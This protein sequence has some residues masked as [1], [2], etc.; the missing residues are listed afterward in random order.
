MYEHVC[1]SQQQKIMIPN[2]HTLFVSFLCSIEAFVCD[3]R[4]QN[5][6]LCLHICVILIRHGVHVTTRCLICRILYD[7]INRNNNNDF[8]THLV[9]VCWLFFSLTPLH[10]F[11]GYEGYN[12]RCCWRWRW[13]WW[14]QWM[15]M[16]VLIGYINACNDNNIYYYI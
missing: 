6:E 10:Y 2:F 4:W 13:W 3:A 15:T 1:V 16:I 12:H 8:E 7:N 11:L 14:W 5:E 9:A